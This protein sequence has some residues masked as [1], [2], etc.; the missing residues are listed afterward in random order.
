MSAPAE[1]AIFNPLEE[2]FVEWPYDQYRR[3]RAED[4]VHRSELLRGW[5]VT[6]YADVSAILRDPSVSAVIDN[7]EPTRRRTPPAAAKTCVSSR[8]SSF[9]PRREPSSAYT[10]WRLSASGAS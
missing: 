2:G 6:R 4:P 1:P 8:F 9:E 10:S 7:A 3:L 5:V